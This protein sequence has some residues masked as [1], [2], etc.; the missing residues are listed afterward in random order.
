MIAAEHSVLVD[1][2]IDGVWEYVKDMR[3]WASIMPGCQ[4]CTVLDE[5]DSLWVLKL[6]VG[7]FVR[8]VKLQVHVD[9]WA[10]PEAVHFSFALEGDPVEGRGAYLA[11][12]KG[13]NETEITMKVR[14]SGGGPMAP[15]WEAMGGPVLSQFA[16]SFAGELKARIEGAVDGSGPRG[17]GWTGMLSALLAGI[18][19]WLR[20]IWRRA[21][22][23]EER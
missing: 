10:A 4:E 17:R 5:D 9:Q 19:G 7:G 2:G 22:R 20:S 6:G 12:S 8:T 21:L 14:I 18:G 1:S 15:M 23:R 11:S 16:K 3:R 13:P